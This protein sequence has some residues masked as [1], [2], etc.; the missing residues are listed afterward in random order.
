MLPTRRQVIATLSLATAPAQQT[1]VSPDRLKIVNI[2]RTTIGG[3]DIEVAKPPRGYRHHPAHG[4]ILHEGMRVT[5]LHGWPRDRDFCAEAR[6]VRAPNGD[7]IV[8]F[9]AGSRHYG[10][11]KT[12]TNEMVLYRSSDRGKTWSGPEIPWKLPY[13]QHA[14]VGLVPRGSKEIYAFGT[15]PRFEDFDG[16]ENAPIGWRKSADNGHTWSEVQWIR[17]INDPGF[18]GMYVFPACETDRGTWILAPHSADWK[19]TPVTTALYIMRS[20]DR[21]RSWTLLPN[22]RPRGWTEPSKG[23][24][25]E[26]R[27]I[28]LGN[29]GVMLMVRTAEGRLW[30]LRSNDDGLTWSKPE[31]TPLIQPS[32]PP[33]LFHLSDGKTLAAFHHNRYSGISSV[34]RSG[35]T[36]QDRAELWVSLSTDAGLTWSKPRFVLANTAEP[37][38]ETNSWKWSVSYVD[39]IIDRGLITLIVAH[40]HK[41]V[42]TVAFDETV[43]AKLAVKE[44]LKG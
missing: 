40:Q 23:R 7:Y 31:P 5:L 33:M 22:P 18:T 13:N 15:E 42:V 34:D 35:N 37:A 11:H 30:Q 3:V 38:G 25:E 10:H 29:G 28:A 20:T 9:P 21:G 1:A 39:A 8:M 43:L 6:G 26:G 41:R 16:D 2:A 12:K 14:F 36:G 44:A 32:A 19:G 17:P 4:L 27:P 24:F